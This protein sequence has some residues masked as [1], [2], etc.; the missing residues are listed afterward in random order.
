MNDVIAWITGV[1]A[2]VVPGFGTTPAPSWNGYVEADYTYVS[3]NSPG[4]IET[5]AV[6]AGDVVTPGQLLFVLKQDQ[7]VALLRAA[8]AR[9]AAAEAN[10]TNLETGS[11]EE[12]VEVIRATL[13]KAAADLVLAETTFA[14]SEKLAAGGLAPEAN[15]DRDRATLRSAE[16]QVKQL[17][18]QLRVAELPARD[19]LQLQAEANLLAAHADADKARSDL[20]DRTVLAQTGGRVERLYFAAGEMATAGTPVLAVLPTHALKIKFYVGE[21]ERPQFA[22]GDVVA[23]SC[24]GCPDG[25]TA[26][27]SYF[28]SDPQ[29]TPPVIYSRDERQR[30]SFLVEATLAADSDLLPGQPVTVR[31][32]E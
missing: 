17:K 28:S 8:E 5:I 4:V 31:R 7:Q 13:D 2:V 24:D 6:E 14:R 9:M 20:A 18:A 30:L 23:V 32:P 29:F 15:V 22:L 10:A 1:I 19:P 16:A 21:A 3:A 25:L 11:R 12:E 27:L 26:T